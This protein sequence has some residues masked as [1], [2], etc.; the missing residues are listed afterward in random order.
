[1]GMAVPTPE[2]L[3]WADCGIGVIIHLDIQVFEPDY[4]FRQSWGYTPAPDVFNPTQLDTDQWLEAAK[5]L[6]AGYAVLVAK[7]CT[8]FSLWPTQAHEYSVKSSRWRN[9]RADIVRDFIASCR[10][11]GIRPGIYC[12]TGCNAFCDVENV[13]VRSADASLQARYNEI[14]FRQLSELWCE[15]GELFE[16]W[17]DGGVPPVYREEIE[18]LLNRLQPKAVCFQGPRSHGSSLR[19]PG[20]EDGQAPYPCWA[21]TDDITQEDGATEIAG[22]HGNPDGSLWAPA[23]CDMPCR[24]Q[25]KAFGGGWFWK[26]G[27]DHLLYSLDYLVERYYCSVGRNGNLL[28][29]MVIDDRGLVP[30][31]D[32]ARFAEFGLEITKRFSAIKGACSGSGHVQEIAMKTSS[33]VTQAVMAEDICHGERVREYTIDAW[34]GGG[35]KIVAGGSCIGHKRIERFAPVIS[36]RFRLNIVKAVSEPLIREFSIY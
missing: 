16:I 14:V 29:G 5:S 28:L 13:F 32:C 1:M 21:A 23:E 11:Y 12:S 2:Q 22:I 35:W 6:G 3:V 27:E 31:A 33:A 30:A 4:N 17:F 8:G 19:W 18:R 34:A 36:D 7:H 9:G 15:Y 20:N 24:S 26:R 25:D 10:R